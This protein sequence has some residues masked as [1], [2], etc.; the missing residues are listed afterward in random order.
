M[1]DDLPVGKILERREVLKLFGLS[2]GAVL[3]GGLSSCTA[4][5]D[6]ASTGRLPNCIVRPELTEGSYFVE[7]RLER[8]DDIRSN[9]ST[10]VLVAGMPLTLN[11]LVSEVGET[12]APL[13]GVIVDIWH[14]DPQGRYSDVNDRLANTVGQTFLRRSDTVF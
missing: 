8:S 1:H 4:A 2:S 11:F 9:S 3:L 14:C 5:Q 10:G 6:A 7:E 13:G 12:C